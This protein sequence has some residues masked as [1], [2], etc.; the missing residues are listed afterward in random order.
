MCP[1]NAVPQKTTA[2][3]LMVLL[4]YNKES[5]TGLHSNLWVLHFTSENKRQYLEHHHLNS[6]PS[7]PPKLKQ[8]LPRCKLMVTIF[9]RIAWSF[10]E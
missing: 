5:N 9:F 6:S 4:C 1:L 2:A 10:T 8:T 7:K 3:A